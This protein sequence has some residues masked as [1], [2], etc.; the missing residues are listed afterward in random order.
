V[1]RRAE[2]NGGEAEGGEGGD[3]GGE[4]RNGRNFRISRGLR[5]VQ[6]KSFLI[7]YA[8]SRL[9]SLFTR[10]SVLLYLFIYYTKDSAMSVHSSQHKN[11]R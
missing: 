7:F 8:I 3:F 4:E 1:T 5:A 6:A 11:F 10:S 9:R 2:R